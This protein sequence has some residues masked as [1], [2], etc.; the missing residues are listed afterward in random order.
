M[1]LSK[2][3]DRIPEIDKANADYQ[4]ALKK[5]FKNEITL[6]ECMKFKEAVSYAC[7]KYG[8]VY[9]ETHPDTAEKIKKNISEKDLLI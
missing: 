5:L 4:E 3:F 7:T 8:R 6:D 1:D 9:S 2:Y